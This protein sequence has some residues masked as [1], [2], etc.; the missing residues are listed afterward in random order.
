MKIV[1]ASGPSGIRESR[2]LTILTDLTVREA[3]DEM[4]VVD[5]RPVGG[6]F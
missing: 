1:I 2:I 3:V 5:H 6:H 4:F